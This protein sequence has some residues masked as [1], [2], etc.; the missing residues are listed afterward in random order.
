MG[1]ERSIL[2]VSQKLTKSDVV[3]RRWSTRW[4]WV[5]RVT[6]WDMEQDRRAQEAQLKEVVEMNKRHA[7][8]A[9]VIQT[10]ALEYLSTMLPSQLKPNTALHFLAKAVEIERKPRA[11]P[12]EI[13]EQRH[14]GAGAGRG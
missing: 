5:A 10:K 2:K 3:L 4:N 6:A 1:A 7:Q 11:E 9:G 14:R 13:V 12:T 8:W